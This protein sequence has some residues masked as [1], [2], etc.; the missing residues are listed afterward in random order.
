M[1]K[2]GNC[3]KSNMFKSGNKFNLK[4]TSCTCI[5]RVLWFVLTNVHL[6]CFTS[7]HMLDLPAVLHQKV[8][9]TTLVY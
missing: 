5:K 9:I 4:Q 3:F 7:T 2:E 8:Q 1:G 6:T